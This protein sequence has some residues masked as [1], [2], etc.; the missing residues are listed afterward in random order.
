MF[1]NY[2]DPTETYDEVKEYTN[3]ELFYNEA[4]H[5]DETINY[6]DELEQKL[7][8]AISEAEYLRDVMH[9]TKNGML[10]RV[11]N[12]IKKLK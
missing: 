10:T 11:K 5:S 2:P 12:L 3:E 7:R 6:V 8:F 4:S 1:N 9:A